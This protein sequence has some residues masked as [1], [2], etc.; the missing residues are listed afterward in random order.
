M[1]ILFNMVFG[2]FIGVYH[3]GGVVPAQLYIGRF[4]KED[5]DTVI[6]WKTYQPPTWLLG[7]VDESIKTVDLMGAKPSR[8]V[9]E[10]ESRA[11]CSDGQ[12]RK[13]NYL[14]APLSATYLDIYLNATN[15]ADGSH[16]FYLVP[17]KVFT[18]HL[19]MDDLDFGDDGIMPTLR[20]VVGRRGLG[21]WE[22]RKNCLS[23][24]GSYLQNL[25]EEV[26]D[27]V[28]INLMNEVG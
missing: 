1:W 16:R 22:I 19:N 28:V 2:L 21:I 27:E 20:R 8:L 7:Q 25:I 26:K 18:Q 12:R 5:A 14:V 3:Q 15:A 11:V 23:S 9:P 10:L 13:M 24:S 4:L 17:V 6:W